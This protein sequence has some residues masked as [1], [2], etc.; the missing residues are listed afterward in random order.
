MFRS[1]LTNDSISAN[2]TTGTRVNV[3]MPAYHLVYVYSV[4]KLWLAYGIAISLS[5]VAVPGGIATMA[6]NGASYSVEFSTVFRAARVAQMSTDV[7]REDPFGSDP[8]P[9]YLKRSRISFS[10]TPNRTKND[11]L[12]AGGL[13]SPNQSAEEVPL[14]PD[15][16]APSAQVVSAVPLRTATGAFSSTQSATHEL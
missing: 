15:L 16:P 10:K 2:S 6:L 9:K 13:Q 12:E 3:T 5:A 8:L 11:S 1:Q 7:D 14:M 4:E